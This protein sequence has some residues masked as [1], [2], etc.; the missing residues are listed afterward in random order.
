MLA[1]VAVWS[2]IFS[3]FFDQARQAQ[4]AQTVVSIISLTRTALLMPTRPAQGSAPRPR[5]PRGHPHLPAEAQ[6]KT[7]PMDD[8]PALRLVTREVRLQLSADTRFA[9]SWEGLSGF[10]VSF[11]IGDGPPTPKTS[12]SCCP[13]SGSCGPMPVNG[14]GGVW[15]P[16]AWPCSAPAIVSRLNR[17]SGPWR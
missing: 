9:A 5:H 1:S 14:C 7:T 16:S 4:T 2:A 8:T 13:S 12:G 15:P 6:D 17:P 3:H 10:W 11:R